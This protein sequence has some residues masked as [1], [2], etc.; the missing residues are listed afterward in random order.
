MKAML[1]VAVYLALVFALGIV[2]ALTAA[3]ES[4]PTDRTEGEM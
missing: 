4:G 2:M 3:P 1:S